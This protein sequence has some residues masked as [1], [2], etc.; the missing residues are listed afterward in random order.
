MSKGPWLLL[1]VSYLAYRAYY[2][3]PRLSFNDIQTSVVYGIVQDIFQL[4][5]RFNTTRIAFCFDYGRPRRAITWPKYKTSRHADKTEEET[6]CVLEVR[7]QVQMLRKE[8]L[9]MVGFRNIIFQ[10]G[11]EAD[12][13]IAAIVLERPTKEF[14][15]VSSDEDLYQLLSPHTSIYSPSKKELMTAERLVEEYGISP[16]QWADVKALAGC[17]GDD[18]DGIPGVGNKTAA[19]FLSGKLKIGKKYESIVANN[20]IWRRNLSLVR[21]PFPGMKEIRLL[22]D[23]VTTEGW[24]QLIELLGMQSLAASIPGLSRKHAGGISRASLNLTRKKLEDPRRKG[25]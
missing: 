16:S 25:R 6:A 5:E 18:V 10:K 1:D 20:K 22:K 24:E 14:I 23:E 7:E 11:Y 13:I 8:F 3:K 17:K 2:S 12:D 19:L 15:I 4:Q 9:S 21:L